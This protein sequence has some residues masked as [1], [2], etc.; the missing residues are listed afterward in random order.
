MC[1]FYCYLASLSCPDTAWPRFKERGVKELGAMFK[2]TRR[3]DEDSRR[4]AG[5]GRREPGEAWV[6]PVSVHTQLPH[7]PKNNFQKTSLPSCSLPGPSAV[8]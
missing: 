6:Q 1:D 7:F 3:L 2:V 8:I 4:V 5:E